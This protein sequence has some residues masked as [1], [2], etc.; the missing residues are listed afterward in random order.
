MGADWHMGLSALQR[1]ARWSVAMMLTRQLDRE[2]TAAVRAQSGPDNTLAVQAQRHEPVT[3][4][5]GWRVQ[6]GTGQARALGAVSWL[7]DAGRVELQAA[8]VGSTN[9]TAVRATASGGVIWLGGMPVAG[10]AL[11]EGVAAQIEVEGMP[12]VGIRLNHRDVAVTDATG[13]AWVH[14]LQPWQDNVIGVSAEALPMDMLLSFPEMRLRPRA[15][16]VVQAKFPARRSRSVLLAV[17]M[18]GGEPVAAGSRARRADEAPGSGAPFA[19]GGK[20]YLNDVE[21]TNRIRI[22]G[23]QGVCHLLFKAPDAAIIQP[24][25][26]PL[27][28]QAHPL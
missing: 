15:Q 18:P 20:V 6:A 28:C 19:Q 16:S 23:P 9:D 12:G 5:P 4:G 24:E 26:G 8:R 14:G 27:T 3:G 11:G 7:G 10:R 17:R 2:T 1:E 21:D 13:R 25:L 22:D